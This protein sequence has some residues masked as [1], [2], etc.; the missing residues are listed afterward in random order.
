MLMLMKCRKKRKKETEHFQN[1]N[2][3]QTK[4]D[5]YFGEDVKKFKARY[6]AHFKAEP[7]LSSMQCHQLQE[8]VSVTPDFFETLDE[9]LQKMKNIGEFKDK[10]GN[11]YKPSVSF[12]LKDKNYSDLRNGVYDNR[13]APIDDELTIKVEK[14]TEQERIEWLNN[15]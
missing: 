11:G 9:V 12:L 15:L 13:A 3:L 8:L 6:K 1:Y 4:Q 2:R 14:M 10:D 7:F 5:P